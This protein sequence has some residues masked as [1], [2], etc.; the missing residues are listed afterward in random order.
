[1][2]LQQ[3][4]ILKIILKKFINVMVSLDDDAH[5]WPTLNKYF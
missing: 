5:L 3:Q 4:I 2:N 1:M